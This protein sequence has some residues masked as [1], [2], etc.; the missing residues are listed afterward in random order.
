MV[1]K[2]LL[3]PHGLRNLVNAL[4][5]RCLLRCYIV[6]W[7]CPFFPYIYQLCIGCLAAVITTHCSTVQFNVLDKYLK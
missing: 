1:A 4:F 3:L 6:F 2:S 7:W 5:G